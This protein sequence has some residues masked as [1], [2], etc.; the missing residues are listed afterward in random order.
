MPA[1]PKIKL[2]PDP[3]RDGKKILL[4]DITG[5]YDVTDNPGGYGTPNLDS[6]DVEKTLLNVYRYK[7]DSTKEVILT[8]DFPPKDTLTYEIDSIFFDGGS[9][10]EVL[11]DSVFKVTYCPFW[12]APETQGDVTEGTFIVVVNSDIVTWLDDNEPS[13]ILIND[14]KYP[15]SSWELNGGNTEITIGTAYAGTDGTED[16]FFGYC[17]EE[18]TITT[19]NANK[20]W[21]GKVSDIQV[22]DLDCDADKKRLD[23]FK[24]VDRIFNGLQGAINAWRCE[25]YDKSQ[26]ML[27]KINAI[28]NNKC[29]TC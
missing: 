25:K 10:Q 14:V 21:S 27:D 20:C 6:A 28:C 7:D 5:V 16:I 15:I 22:C 11:D 9:V 13:F 19:F 17:A 2:T 23:K 1:V 4:T 24:Q 8:S 3:D 29:K 26:S 18:T 12:L